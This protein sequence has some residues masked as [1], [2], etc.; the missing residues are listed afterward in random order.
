VCP[1]VSSLFVWLYFLSGI[2]TRI[3]AESKNE[4]GEGVGVLG[5]YKIVR[6][7]RVWTRE[8]RSF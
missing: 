4:V 1:Y 8:L 5:R 7:G 2:E 6:R 3:S